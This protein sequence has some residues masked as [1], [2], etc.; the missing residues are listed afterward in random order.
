MVEPAKLRATP[1][2]RAQLVGLDVEC[3]RLTGNGVAFEEEIRNPK[4]VVDIARGHLKPNRLAQ[5]QHQ[6]G[7]LLRGS[8]ADRARCRTPDYRAARIAERPP[9]AVSVDVD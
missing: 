7:R 6:F 1:D 9:P 5:R 4:R 3:R 8:P 2:E